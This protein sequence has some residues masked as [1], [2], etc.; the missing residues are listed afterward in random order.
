MTTQRRHKLWI[1]IA[2]VGIAA[3]LGAAFLA[4][5]KP[6]LPAPQ[7]TAPPS[8][9]FLAS[10]VMQV[11]PHDLREILTLSGALRAVNQA[12][13]K[14]RVSG[15]VREVLVREGASVSSGQV[16]VK[17]DTSEYQARVN[18][19]LGSQVAA[20]GQLDIASKTRANNKVLVEKGFIS[21]NAFDNAASQYD[22]AKAN[23]DSANGALDVARKALSD[24]VIRA[25]I[26]GLISRRSVEPG[27]KVSPDNNLLEIVDLRQMEMAA[28]VPTSNILSVALG[29]EVRLTLGGLPAPVVGKVVRI[30]P[31]IETGSR[32][33]MVYIQI[34][35]PQGL[36][37]AGM[38]GEAQLTL[39]RKN[40]VLT[41][42]QSA[43]QSDA[44]DHYVYLIENGKVQRRSVTLGLRGS[45]GDSSNA[46]EIL[47]GVSNGARIVKVNLGNL[48]DGASVK[49]L[50]AKPAGSQG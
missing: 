3:V 17:M 5:R 36:L 1:A 21:K 16:I 13:V 25:P 34:D 48:P 6:P 27:E 31:S 15:E 44:S 43:I 32:S 12:Q 50:A 29:Q 41:A 20:Q 30:N 23:V 39:S 19:A 2:V 26:S 28:A 24:T 10:D 46:V 33:I 37:R 49:V 38:F 40:G 22:I 47:S 11:A 9:E 7:K 45:D 18:Q 35:N 42:P 14:A 4:Q 8:L